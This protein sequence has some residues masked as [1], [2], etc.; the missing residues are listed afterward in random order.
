MLMNRFDSGAKYTRYC[1]FGVIASKAA[2]ETAK[3]I[4]SFPSYP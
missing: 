2:R 3:R 1:L 4:P